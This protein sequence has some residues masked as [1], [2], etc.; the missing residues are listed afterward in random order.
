MIE[1]EAIEG[2]DKVARIFVDENPDS[3]R[4]FDNLG[5]MFCIDRDYRFGDEF[6]EKFDM[7]ED[8]DEVEKYLI[9]EY[10]AE[11]ILPL[12]I[13][14]YSSCNMRISTNMSGRQ[15]GFIFV[16]RDSIMKEY[17]RKKMSK[18]LRYMVVE[19]LKAEIDL[20]EK[21]ANREVYGYEI[22]SKVVDDNGDVSEKLLDSCWGFCGFDDVMEAIDEEMGV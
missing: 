13:R 10:G 22:Y 3:P 20:Y 11:V 4:E 7:F 12:F 14:E 15:V 8:W 16:S 1:V 17:N 19:V 2:S 5:R 6:L 18:K 21:Y 9:D